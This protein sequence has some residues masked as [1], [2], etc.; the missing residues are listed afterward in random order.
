MV[1]ALRFF[2][3]ENI[4]QWKVCVKKE[5]FDFGYIRQ[6]YYY[7]A[8]D[9]TVKAQARKIIKK[10][11]DYSC[12]V[13]AAWF[14]AA[15]LATAELKK[16]SPQIKAV[17]LAHSYEIFVSRNKYIPYL[18]VE[19]KHRFLDGVFFI[20]NKAREMYF[21]G[22][23]HL[24]KEYT[25]K[26]HV[27]YLGS[28]KNN[29]VVNVNNPN[30]FHICTCSRMVALKRLDVLLDALSLW[31]DGDIYWT[32]LGNGE[33][34]MMLREKAKNVMENNHR[35]HIHFTG[36]MPN[37]MVKTYYE[38]HPVDLFINLSSTE[39]LPI[40]IMEAISY[41]LPV[42]ATDVGG[43]SEIVND[44]FGILID[45]SISP[46]IVIKQILSFKRL[47]EETRNEY[48]EKAYL[49]WK[50]YF[51]AENNMRVLFDAINAI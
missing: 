26:T 45:S 48:R 7:L 37:E 2:S 12:T 11:S 9:A 36:Y 28:F 13:L 21:E 46:E 32:H 23:G 14:A 6:L 27:K 43:T 15:A 41:G 17:S 39:G 25:D 33:L 51:D 8:A 31:D 20:A 38:E 44:S 50:N 10:K 42:I 34:E 1:A 30:E 4:K 24:K 29:D 3:F 40:S 5:G 47:P 35:V 16:N 18:Y 22:I 19:K 49:H